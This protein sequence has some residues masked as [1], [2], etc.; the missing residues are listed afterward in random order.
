MTVHDIFKE[1][2]GLIVSKDS[3]SLFIIDVRH[4]HTA[5]Y[6]VHKTKEHPGT[7][8]QLHLDLVMRQ[9]RA[10]IKKA[11]TPKPTKSPEHV[12]SVRL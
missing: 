6:I 10:S 7:A 11:K 1:E 3:Y 8:G 12:I 2:N 9:D 4:G 5:V